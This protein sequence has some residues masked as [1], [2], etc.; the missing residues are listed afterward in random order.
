MQSDLPLHEVLF[1]LELSLRELD[2]GLIS[3]RGWVGQKGQE[4][5]FLLA[6][7]V[8]RVKGFFEIS[9]Q[10][11]LLLYPPQPAKKIQT[12]DADRCNPENGGQQGGLIH[13]E[14]LS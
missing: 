11:P 8:R 13:R 7:G 14:F 3:L 5:P 10:P 2:S 12:E 9:N 1:T 4:L 6:F